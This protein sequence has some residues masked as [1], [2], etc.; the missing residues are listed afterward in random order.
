MINET[1]Q[2]LCMF[3]KIV[4]LMA[5]ASAKMALKYEQSSSFNF[6][7]AHGD[8]TLKSGVC[9]YVLSYITYIDA[10]LE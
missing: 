10:R 2:E 5:E 9:T 1:R 4:W 7:S 8:R 6:G 3:D